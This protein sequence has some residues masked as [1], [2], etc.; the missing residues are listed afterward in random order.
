MG[1]RYKNRS[2]WSRKCPRVPRE[3]SPSLGYVSN[4][5]RVIPRSASEA[6]VEPFRGPAYEPLISSGRGA[7]VA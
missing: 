2:R 3:R 5:P 4:V 7:R 1:F 6:A